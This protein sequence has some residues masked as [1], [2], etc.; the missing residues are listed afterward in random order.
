MIKTLEEIGLTDAEAKVYLALLELGSTTAGPLVKKAEL[1]RTTVYDCLK[2][3]AEKGMVNYVLIR[4]MKYFEAADPRILMNILKEKEGKLEEILPELE[5]LKGAGKLRQEVNVYQGIKGMKTVCGNMIEDL[6]DGGE[7]F[8]FGVSGLFRE[9]MGSYW[10]LWQK[11]KMK[12]GIKSYVIFNEDVKEKNPRL[13]KDYYGEAR[14]HPKEYSS[15]TDTIIYDDKVII[16]I[17]TARPPLAIVIKNKDNAESYKNQ[18]K[19]MWKF[20]KR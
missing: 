3:L 11:Q 12:Y 8:D 18:F 16:F 17:W 9:V 6:K 1:H 14:F 2:R 5:K 7:Y 20:S 13:L 19:L 4:K 10:S 15:I